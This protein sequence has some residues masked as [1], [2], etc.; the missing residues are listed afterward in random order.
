MSGRR[1]RWMALAAAGVVAVAT[2]LWL[3]TAFERGVRSILLAH[4][5]LVREAMDILDQREAA[6]EAERRIASLSAHAAELRHDPDS[7]VAGN[8]DG[9]VTVVEFFDYRCPYCREFNLQ[10]AELLAADSGIRFV[11][12]EFPILGPDST[13]AAHAALAAR[14]Q[15]PDLYPAFHDALMDT[16]GPLDARALGEIVEVFGLGGHLL[17]DEM[18][19]AAIEKRIAANAALAEAIGIDGTPGFVIGDAVVVGYVS[20]S[21]ILDLVEQARAECRSCQ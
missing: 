20:A 16:V 2:A 15:E 7:P 14:W 1:W 17:E 8:P 18:A 4:S 9:D 12:K 13:L 6:A 3:P 11:Y 10:L 5:E 21:V 19:D